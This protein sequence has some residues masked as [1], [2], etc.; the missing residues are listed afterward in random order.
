MQFVFGLNQFYDHKEESQQIGD[1][2]NRN[3]YN[4]Q[5]QHFNKIM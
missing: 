1:I 3:Q 5:F 2:I 4:I